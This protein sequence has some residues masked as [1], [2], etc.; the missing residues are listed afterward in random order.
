[1]I[2]E[3]LLNDADA[4]KKRGF[5]FRIIDADSRIY[6]QFD[7][8]PV[9]SKAYTQETTDLLIFTSPSYPYAG[10]DMFW[11]DPNLFL[12]D[13]ATPRRAQVMKTYLNKLWRRFSYHPYQ[14]HPWN[15]AVD[16]VGR[17]VAYVE[18]RLRQ[19]D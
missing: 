4:L 10:F 2:P 7:K 11:T 16:D 18:Q 3:E 5:D 17:F 9:P 13:G 6:I 1:M 19:G 15:P 8:F 14:D 12:K